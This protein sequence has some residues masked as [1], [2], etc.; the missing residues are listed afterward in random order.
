MNWVSFYSSFI[1]SFILIGF[2]LWKLSLVLL[3]LLMVLL[4]LVWFVYDSV[5]ISIHFL[6]GF[7]LF[8]MSEV[9]IFL[10]LFVC[11][12][13]FRDVNDISISEYNELP[14]LG[15]FF[16]LGS[17]ITATVF[18]LQMNVSSLFLWLTI[19]LGI[20]FIILQGFEYNESPVNLFSSVYH[21]CCFTTISLHFSHVLLGVLLLLGLLYYSPKVVNLY[22]SN[23]IVW[24][25]HFVD[26]IWLLVYTVVYIF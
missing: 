19:L 6:N 20:F 23:L 5:N 15:S 22:Y 4:G 7:F 8:I 3:G 14:L 17:S 24:Y 13:W 18:H 10:S 21:A 2:I 11:C 12:L 26:Y 9:I 16:L 1:F 25:W